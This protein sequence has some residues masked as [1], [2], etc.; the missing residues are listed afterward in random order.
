MAAF[1]SL[2]RQF[3]PKGVQFV[4]LADDPPGPA[5]DSA[6]T[7][8]PWRAAASVVG[9]ADGALGRLFDQSREAPTDHPYRVAFVLPSFLLVDADGRV[10]Q[11]AFGEADSLFRPALDSLVGDGAKFEVI[12]SAT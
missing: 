9:V 6:L 5:L 8:A 10:V 2:A 11:R 7:A 4:L 3:G 1:D 12:S